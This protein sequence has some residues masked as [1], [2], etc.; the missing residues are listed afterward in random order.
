MRTNI[1]SFLLPQLRRRR[2]AGPEPE[3]SNRPPRPISLPP[4]NPVSI[5][6]SIFKY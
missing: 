4:I 3:P 1:K 6:I 5:Y 2:E